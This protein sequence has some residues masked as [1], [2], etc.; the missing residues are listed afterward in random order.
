M[1]VFVSSHDADDAVRTFRRPGDPSGPAEHSIERL[2]RAASEAEA[3]ERELS[4]WK[5]RY[6]RD[7]TPAILQRVL[8]QAAITLEKEIAF[9][10]VWEEL[11]K[12]LFAPVPHA[13][14]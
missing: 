1:A 9:D 5:E 8:M 13:D 2:L 3:A 7:P 14:P 4:E 6:Q 10:E 12:T 11:S